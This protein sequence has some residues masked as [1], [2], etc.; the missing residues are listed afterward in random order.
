MS[1]QRNTDSR[2]RGPGR[3]PGQR[4]IRNFTASA[5]HFA[6]V[7]ALC[8]GFAAASASAGDAP[9][10]L[11]T[12]FS[13]SVM[14]SGETDRVFLRVGLRGI[15]PP[16]D[17]ERSPANIALVIDRSG[18]MQGEKIED[19]REA[20]I[21][22]LGRLNPYDTLSV[23]AFNEAVDVV[24]PATSAG[25][26]P[27]MRRAIR[28]I[29]AQ[30]RTALY[31]GVATGIDEALTFL[32]PYAVNRVILLSDGLANVGPTS[33]DEIAE[34]G[35]D[36]AAEGISITTIGLGLGYNEDL[37]TRLAL[38]SDGNHAFVEHPDDLVDIFNDEFGDVFSVV[39]QG[40]EVEIHFPEGI[41][42]L[43]ALGRPAEIDGRNVSFEMRQIYGG[44][45][46]YV[47]FE[48]EIDGA[49]ARDTLRA[50][51]V[52]A[53]YTDMRTKQKTTLEDSV[54]LSFSDDA[55]R[56]EASRNKD[57]LSAATMQI[58]TERSERAVK[59]RDNGKV[60]EARKVLQ[61]NAA[62][63]KEKADEL[64][65]PQLG[66]LAEEQESDAAAISDGS[67]WNKQRKQMRSR[68]HKGKTQ[69]AY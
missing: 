54:S 60:E 45:E 4:R 6:A 17:I 64:A 28:H 19:A 9:V 68:Q 1:M 52:S 15:R 35:R 47:L 13:Q 56:I 30:G 21:M 37:M 26:L 5:V 10:K 65:A 27:N 25:D 62:Y 50:A 11:D 67:G 59:L 2:W 8:L 55:E 63:L 22:A 58:A 29:R 34:L 57:V 48:V 12:A 24:L 40:A 16:E 20:A 36:A 44:Q 14:T 42:P 23:V 61:D 41:R 33:P 43:R 31:D 51:E 49:A 32:D 39:G 69:Q 53:S 38:N 46:K 7:V 3:T 66:A 18:S